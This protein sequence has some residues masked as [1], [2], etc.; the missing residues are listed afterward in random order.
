MPEQLRFDCY[1]E[2]STSKASCERRGCCWLPD[3]KGDPARDPPL[4]VPYCFYPAL[5]PSYIVMNVSDA[6]YGKTLFLT[7]VYASGYPSDVPLLRVDVK[8][9][10][11]SRLRVKI[12]DPLKKRYEVPWPQVPDVRT[13]AKNPLYEFD[14]SFRPFGFRVIRKDNGQ[15]VFDT[16][17]VGSLIFADQM[18]QLSSKLPS[19]YIYGLGEH[20]DNFLLSTNWRK[21]T[22]FNHDRL[23]QEKLNLY[24]S[25]P[26]YLSMENTGRSNGVFMFNSNAMGQYC[27]TL[28]FG[29][30]QL[31]FFFYSLNPLYYGFVNVLIQP[32]P[33]ITFRS[34]GGIM[35]MY[36]FLGPSPKDVIE[37]YTT[38]IGRPHMPPF[39]A[40]GFHLCRFGWKK[41]SDS[42][43]ALARTLKNQIPL[44]VMWSDIDY[45]DKW[46]DFSYDN[47]SYAGLP[48]YVN[49][50]HAG[51]LHYVPIIDPGIS[52]AEEPGT[53]LPFDEGK[54]LGIF[55][56]NVTG[57]LF[58]GKVWN[59]VSTVW[60][61]FTHPKATP[62]WTNQLTRYHMQ[63]EFDGA[64]IDMNEPSN[65][66]DGEMHGCPKNDALEQPPYLP[67]VEGGKLAFKTVC[68]TA[69]QHASVHYNVHNLYGFTESI[70][71][72]F[73]LTDI[74]QKR[75]FVISRSTFPGQ[76][77]FGGHWTGDVVSTWNAMSKSIPAMLNFNMY[78][79]PLVG[80]DIC[81]FNGNTTVNL[82]KRWSELGAFYPFSRNHNSEGNVDQDPAALGP[83][84][85]RS[86]RTSLRLRYRLLPYLYTLFWKAHSL[87]QAVVRPLF[88]EF[89]EDEETYKIDN[90]FFWGA[91][92]LIA[93]VLNEYDESYNYLPA[94]LWYKL[95]DGAI[96]N[97]TGAIYTLKPPRGAP[98]LLVRGGH[99]LPAI[100]PAQTTT[101]MR[102]KPFEVIVGLDHRG[103]A[104]GE[105]YWDDGDSIGT[106]EKR[107]FNL[108]EFRVKD[109]KLRASV[110]KWG[111]ESTMN[112]SRVSIF[113][114]TVRSE[115]ANVTRVVVNNGTVSSK[116]VFD[117][118][119]GQL[120]I[121]LFS[122]LAQ[123][124]TVEW[125]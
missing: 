25:H 121:T 67:G 2:G 4:N 96:I 26:F 3:V 122:S 10:T 61:D 94:G 56:R 1:P 83:D 69:R 6:E 89:P 77:R 71:T 36:F 75:P 102:S 9:E 24:G 105:L 13:A 123:P 74:R 93:P 103:E 37:Q 53:Y 62:Y 116:F 50:L 33:A 79:I 14:Y 51:G 99:V 113:G 110:N 29:G 97:S 19:S 58:I 100:Q 28:Y 70:V 20:Q 73:A 101:E 54:E 63:V 55:I 80:A 81:G 125:S 120:D 48:E 90:C 40:L 5:Y 39:W 59:P 8:F 115:S 27:P 85:V 64:W 45:M 82:C 84:V 12:Y 44:D 112:L 119:S 104:F 22:L 72:N 34:I 38:L 60:V 46:K 95:S 111:Y 21:F 98:T 7:R 42:E 15:V 30:S 65:F 41:L 91:G 47:E 107:F 18:L 11:D 57:D 118:R 76:G 92:L 124:L 88:F 114:V 35:D 109:Q 31:F 17:D 78:G 106:W 49:K 86:A 117:Q 43:D 16:K 32:T 87:G 68:M 52:S 66:Y 23:P 108:I